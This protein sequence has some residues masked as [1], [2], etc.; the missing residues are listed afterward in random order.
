MIRLRRSTWLLLLSLPV[1]AVCAAGDDAPL[2]RLP[3]SQASAAESRTWVEGDWGAAPGAFG[4]DD[5]ASRPGPMDFA[6]HNGAL[7]VLDPVNARV[8][9]FN[10]QGRLERVIPIGT[11]TAD[12]LAV[13]DDGSVVVLDAFVKRELR[14]VTPSG[15]LL[16]AA[17]LP[18][19]LSLPSAIF[20]EHGRL[21]VEERHSRVF[22]LQ[23][24]RGAQDQIARPGTVLTGRPRGSAG[25]MFSAR[26]LASGEVA[27][28]QAEG[29]AAP[30]R[31]RVSF[32]REVHAIVALESDASGNTYLAAACSPDQ[33]A[34]QPR[35]DLVVAKLAPSGQVLGTLV[36][37]DQYVTDHYRKLLVTPAGDV[38]QMQTAESGVRFVWWSMS[39]SAAEGGAR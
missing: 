13:D 1:A 11:R 30:S 15:D 35:R 21:L 6:V 3:Q 28:E 16:T 8:Q 29:N 33:P 24:D 18:A 37:P 38:L 4:M 31:L 20:V 27:I 36:V 19:S 5:E 9:V 26:K 23:L 39:P 34:A 2:I 7:Y 17:R 14:V 32:P 25:G 22:P 10:A 12:F